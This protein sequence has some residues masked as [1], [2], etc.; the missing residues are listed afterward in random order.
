MSPGTR[1]RWSLDGSP[2]P[3][4]YEKYVMSD[5]TPQNLYR[6]TLVTK[7]MDK[8]TPGRK[9]VQAGSTVAAIS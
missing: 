6:L 4:L 9:G 7:L 1:E 3:K 8:A 2:V 5:A